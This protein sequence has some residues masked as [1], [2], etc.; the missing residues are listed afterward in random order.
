MFYRDT[1]AE[2]NLDALR[3]NCR[4]I[5]KLTNKKMI[6]V[7]KANAYG[8][9]DYWVAKTAMEEGAEMVAVAYMDEA[10]ALRKQGFTSEILVLGH[11][12]CTDIALASEYRITLTVISLEWLKECIS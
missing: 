10:L 3:H 11:I 5:Q 1:W 8:H 12:R 7:L 2:I 9:C 4:E 6:A